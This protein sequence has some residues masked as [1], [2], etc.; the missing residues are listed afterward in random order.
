MSKSKI[1]AALSLAALSFAAHA[2]GGNVGVYASENTA[3]SG[4]GLTRAEVRAERDAALAR[5]EL[6]R[7][8]EASPL[9]AAQP[10]TRTRGEVQ[11]ELLEAIRLGV[12]GS[13]GEASP[14]IATPAQEAQIAA[15]GRAAAHR[16]AAMQ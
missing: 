13:G 2:G 10:S 8:G 16:F 14:P 7:F 11:A 15:A 9:V 3:R 6:H 5:G 12:Y 1:V 4:A